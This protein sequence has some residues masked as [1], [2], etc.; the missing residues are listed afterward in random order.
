M[1]K[2]CDFLVPNLDPLSLSLLLSKRNASKRMALKS[3]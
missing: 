3:I 1:S 2:L